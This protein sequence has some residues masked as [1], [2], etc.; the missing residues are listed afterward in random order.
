MALAVLGHYSTRPA[1]AALILTK[2]L[3]VSDDRS[4][5]SSYLK[6]VLRVQEL[7]LHKTAHT[8]HDSRKYGKIN[9]SSTGGCY[10]LSK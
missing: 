6:P 10:F 4:G 1:S 3:Y 7:V 9:F 2:A 8:I 5:H